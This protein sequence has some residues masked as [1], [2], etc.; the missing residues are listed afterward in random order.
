MGFIAVWRHRNSTPGGAKESWTPMNAVEPINHVNL[1]VRMYNFLN[2]KE[3][4][5]Q[6]DE[7]RDA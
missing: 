5:P 6:S 4:T 3:N 1:G 2:A 7:R